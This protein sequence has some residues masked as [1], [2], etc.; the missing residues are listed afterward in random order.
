MA[1]HVV[2]KH[3]GILSVSSLFRKGDLLT[4]LGTKILQMKSF[5][6]IWVKGSLKREV[7]RAVVGA[8]LGLYR[9]CWAFLLER[10]L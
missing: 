6:S 1:E 2:C 4:L 3:P 10:M 5:R 9:Q 8:G 7:P